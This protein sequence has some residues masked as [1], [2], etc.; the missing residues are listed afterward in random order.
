MSRLTRESLVVVGLLALAVPAV[1]AETPD[2]QRDT[3]LV[4]HPEIVV[5]ATRTPRQQVERAQRHGRDHAAT[6]CGGAARAR[7]PRRSR[8]S[9][10]VDTGEGSDNGS[11]FPNVGMW[12]L[13]EFDALLF[14]L[15]G[16]PVGGP[17]NP[18]LSQ[19]PIDDVDRIEIVKGPQGTMYGVSAF[20]GHDPGVHAPEAE[21]A[22]RSRSAAARAADS[23][24]GFT[25]GK[26]LGEG[27]DLGLM[28]GYGR[29][30]GWQDRTESDVFRGGATLGFGLGAGRMTVDLFGYQDH[31]DWGSPLPYDAGELVPGFEI[32]R[33]YAVGGAEVEHQVFGGTAQLTWPVGSR[34]RLENTLGVT[35]DE[36]TY[37]RSFPGLPSNDSLVSEGLELR[38]RG[39][40]GLRGRAAGGAPGRAPGRTSWWPAPP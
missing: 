27:R 28:A 18:S 12:G 37:V 30:D 9:S 34:H 19:I 23:R 33:N 16:V 15:N 2:A 8:T 21:R 6:S 40:V 38:P 11:R 10:G 22:A 29:S 24:A 32:D 17:F 25:W 31:Q 3:L 14:T 20:A 7:W 4:H 5:S 35:R 26:P 13:K 36:Q 39:A 1:A